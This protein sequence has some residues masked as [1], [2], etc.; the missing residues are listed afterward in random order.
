[1]I[2]TARFADSIRKMVGVGPWAQRHRPAGTAIGRRRW[3]RTASPSTCSS[4]SA[5]DRHL[6]A[7]WRADRRGRSVQHAAR[8]PPHG[9]SPR[10]RAR[11]P[12]RRPLRAS[13]RKRERPSSGGGRLV[14]VVAGGG[15]TSECPLGAGRAAV[16]GSCGCVAADV[17]TPV[18]PMADPAVARVG[19]ARRPAQR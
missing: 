7:R 14:S 2:P 18:L 16:C 3:S 10:H 11:I 9:R 17:A 6:D 4:C 8:R 15:A 12:R 13:A 5:T 1:M 19:C